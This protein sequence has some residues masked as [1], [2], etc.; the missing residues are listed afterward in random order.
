M[1]LARNRK[2]PIAVEYLRKNM[3][4]GPNFYVIYV[5]F[6]YEKMLDFVVFYPWFLGKC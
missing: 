2:G 1:T 4:I 3:E 5:N 6:N